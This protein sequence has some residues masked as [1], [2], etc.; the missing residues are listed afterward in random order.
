MRHVLAAVLLIIYASYTVVML[1]L[2]RAV[3]ARVEHG[4]YFEAIFRGEALKPRAWPTAAQVSSELARYWSA[5]RV[6]RSDHPVLRTRQ[7]ES[8]RALADPESARD[9]AAGK[10]Q[11]GGLDPAEQGPSRACQHHRCDGLPVLHPGRAGTCVFAVAPD[12]RRVARRHDRACI[13]GLLFIN[14]RDSKLGTP[15][16]AIGGA[17]YAVFIV[18][19]VCLGAF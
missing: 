12:Q 13:G 16:L 3:D 11:L 5:H 17:A 1:R 4:L 10:I 14:L 9:R 15:A 6:R 18:G 2:R 7:S 8:R 19:L